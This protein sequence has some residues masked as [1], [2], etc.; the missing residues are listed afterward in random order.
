MIRFFAAHPTIAN[1][2]MLIILLLGAASLPGL[3]KETFPEIK[4]NQVQVTVA[5]PG[6]SASEVEEG[7]CNRL[8]DSTDGISFLD[9][10]RCE[11]RDN[12]GIMILDMQEIGDIKQFM[13]DVI[14]EVDAID[15]FPDDAEDPVFRELGRTK[16]VVSVAINA[17][18]SQ[19]ELKALA[20]H[21][22]SRMLALPAIPMVE[23]SG[24]STHEFS[25]LIKAETLRRFQ[26]SITDIA[27]LIQQQAVDLPAGI[28]EAEQ[29]S[30]QIRVENERRSI[31]ELS[32]LVILNDEKGGRLK[33]G[34]IATIVDEFTD[35]EVRVELNGRP[36]ALLKISKN[37]TDDTL[38]VFN[39]VKNFVESEN[40]VLPDSTRLVITQDS[41]S[42]VQERLSLLL[43]NGWQGLFL[44]TLSLFLFFSWRYTFWVALGLPI[45]FVGGL[46]FMTVLGISIN[47]ISMVALLMAI[48]I[49]MDDAIVIS[50]SIEHEYQKG[51]TPLDATVDGI[52]KVARG[53]L[54]SFATSAML[55]GSL[56]FLKGDMGQIMGVLPVVLLS[57]LTIS[58]VEA[59]LI[60]P[61]HLKHSLEKHQNE[62]KSQWRLNFEKKFDHL[63]D[64]VVQFAKL[65]ITY[66][67][68]TV[69]VA[70]ALLIMTISLFP[71]GFIKFK[72]FPDLEGDILETRLI[73]P[74]G[75]PFNRTETVVAEL[76]T[77]LQTAVK[78]LP[79]EKRVIDENGHETEGQLIKQI[80][81]FYG[82]NAD[83]G[84]DGPH[85]ATISLDLLDAEKR[86]TSLN[87]LR[88][89]WLKMTPPIADAISIQFK[90]PT[91]GPAGKA[92]SIR[93]QDNDL[94]RLSKASWELQTWLSGYPGV[95]NIMDD[96]RPGKPQFTVSLNPGSL[97][98][99]LNAQQLALQ[100]RAAYQGVK[101]NDVYKGREAYEINVKL[102]IDREHALRD[103]EQLSLFNKQGIDIP[104]NAIAD[105][106]EKR[107]FST[108]TRINHQRTITI[109]GDIDADISNTNE[110]INDTRKQFLTDLQARYPGMYISLE[111]EVKN[112]KETN[113]SV[114][115]GFILGIIGVYFLLSFQF[116]N[117]REPFV[118]L[119]NIPL[120]LI[121][122]VWG[123]KLMGLD[124]TM[125]SMIG[126]VSLAG[127]VVNDSILLVEFVKRRSR[128]GLLL[129]DAASQAVRDRFRAILLT[130]VTTVAGMLPLLFE[131][132]LQAQI[133]VPIVTSVV[134][135]MLSSTVL[136]LLVLPA[137]YAIMEDLNLRE[138]EKDPINLNRSTIS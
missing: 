48:G 134:F 70:I 112:S 80:Q 14:S 131:T 93:L 41:A 89:T 97:T 37:T 96:L 63:R 24:F 76:I 38:S 109:S 123:H 124:I 121:G 46:M 36:A 50:E 56:L 26:L 86:I 102:D 94:H 39:A 85:L 44:A 22:R 66:R 107:E 84:E 101:I 87:E 78:Q 6:A 9:E 10:R 74:Q 81:V 33:L 5:Y 27:N 72:A 32:D 31:E 21:Y 114:L 35:K 116:R 130:S 55:F 111:G 28:L 117:Y 57:V 77:S 51:K 62:K 103:F 60:L 106:S 88:R 133:L 64:R 13:D 40:A 34:D 79:P 125:P 8:E 129:H 54:A 119:M 90:E 53:V 3:N 104:L 67:Y 58:L 19:P 73:M 110:I 137:A 105:I 100:L 118:V 91:M 75:T 16:P 135:G 69:G 120:A 113:S 47:M 126:F 92:I 23:V 42:V 29:R 108:I 132:S 65:A 15:D 17:D 61:H 7:I 1:I 20:E 82:T 4:F 18:L 52:G 25:V 136:L 128:E 83:A 59:F 99:G 49:L 2:L 11:A 43:T 127:I 30:Y 115:V 98:S 71:A 95:S 12:V 45:S 138:T 68:L 122:V